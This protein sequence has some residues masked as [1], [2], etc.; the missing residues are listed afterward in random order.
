MK[1]SSRGVLKEFAAFI[2]ILLLFGVSFIGYLGWNT[3]ASTQQFI[4]SEREVTPI[5]A[6]CL[7][8]IQRA[9]GKRGSLEEPKNGGGYLSLQEGPQDLRTLHTMFFP[10]HKPAQVRFFTCTVR[11]AGTG[12]TVTAFAWEH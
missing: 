11:P 3:Y 10:A 4:K 9:L 8:Y 6:T 12:Y 7:N 5:K 2:G 1:T